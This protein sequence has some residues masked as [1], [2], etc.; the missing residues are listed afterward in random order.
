MGRSFGLPPADGGALRAPSERLAVAALF[1]LIGFVPFAGMVVYSQLYLTRI[2]RLRD[3]VRLT[4]LGILRPRTLRF[5]P[6]A[7]G[8]GGAEYQGKMSAR[9]SVN[10]PWMTL[11][12]RGR[13]LPFVVDMQAEHVDR[14]AIRAL[15]S[16]RA[17]PNEIRDGDDGSV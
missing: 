13:L 17:K 1:W 11:R 3:E 14:S 10:A 9:V 8:D 2:E 15:A 16:R 7:F 5:P 12:V 4:V 6:S